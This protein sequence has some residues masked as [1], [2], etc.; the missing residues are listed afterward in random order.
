[1]T[2]ITIEI[3]PEI[4]ER[5]AACLNHFRD[6]MEMAHAKTN[7]SLESALLLMGIEG[8]EGSIEKVLGQVNS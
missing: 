2:K 7:I 5:W 6:M 4:A 8:Y 1:M 3:E